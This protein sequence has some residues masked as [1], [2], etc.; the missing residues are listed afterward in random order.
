M[1]HAC[2]PR[3]GS[4]R[5]T[6][7]HAVSPGQVFSDDDEM[8]MMMDMRSSPEFG[9][10]SPVQ[11][12][13]EQFPI[14]ASQSRALLREDTLRYLT[15][16][17]INV[18]GYKSFFLFL[19]FVI[20]T[21][22]VVGMQ[23][24]NNSVFLLDQTLQ[25]FAKDVGAIE[26]LDEFWPWMETEFVPHV[27][28]HRWGDHLHSKDGQYITGHYLSGTNV[29]VGGITVTQQR[30]KKV[31]CA[32]DDFSI[33]PSYALSC[34]GGVYQ[35][36]GLT[37]AI[38]NR[39]TIE[40]PFDER[41]HL[42]ELFFPATSSL[43]DIQTQ[44]KLFGESA[45]LG[46]HTGELNIQFIVYNPDMNVMGR[47]K[48]TVRIASS[49]ALSTKYT[50]SSVPF[51]IYNGSFQESW[52]RRLECVWLL[53]FLYHFFSLIQGIRRSYDVPEFLKL[54]PNAFD[55]LPMFY[56][57]NERRRKVH[58]VVPLAM[59]VLSIGLPALWLSILQQYE[60]LHMFNLLTMEG[61]DVKAFVQPL[62]LEPTYNELDVLTEEQ[63]AI[64]RKHMQP[65]W[66]TIGN[67]DA[68][69]QMYFGFA[70]IVC[71]LFIFRSFE[72]FHFQKKLS[73]ITSTIRNVSTDLLHLFFVL[74][75]AIQLFAFIGMVVFGDELTHFSDYGD[76]SFSVWLMTLQIF[77]FEEHDSNFMSD[78][79]LTYFQM[80]YNIVVMTLLMKMVIAILIGGYESI[81]EHREHSNEHVSTVPEDMVELLTM[82]FE[83]LAHETHFV[84][85]IVD[86]YVPPL[87]LDKVLRDK[88]VR[89]QCPRYI[90]WSDL[91]QFLC[92]KCPE[93]EYNFVHV[94]WILRR[95][96][97][98]I[99]IDDPDRHG[100]QPLGE[101]AL[102]KLQET[103]DSFDVEKHG[104][105]SVDQL[106]SAM[107]AMGYPDLTRKQIRSKLGQ[108]DRQHA[109][110]I[111]LDEFCMIVSGCHLDGTVG[112][113]HEKSPNGSP[114]KIDASERVPSDLSLT[115]E[116]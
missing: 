105:M 55:E 15:K 102:G 24:D 71:S 115:S 58:V 56:D 108:I 73:A 57:H 40:L 39:T 46:P 107:T 33:I 9:P 96:G 81:L 52:Q 13:S 27:F 47:L 93:E 16:Y 7:Q 110:D 89:A 32:N 116:Q 78:N 29:L 3:D 88:E 109:G 38:E 23:R 45:I 85:H 99:P 63:V 26:A 67:L 25:L 54:P 77:K 22:G 51:D 114:L 64:F 97:S 100:A 53:L 2:T 72:H 50:I 4:P 28:K 84:R 86:G 101:A 14:M 34:W 19:L 90:E 42:D 37:L 106:R 1:P 44:L 80:A 41:T 104:H 92:D 87:H 59:Y 31:P 43:L 94:E 17:R 112:T 113:H 69:L 74:A 83:W 111:D 103:F 5:N 68:S 61:N 79:D 76:S 62:K 95:Y 30:R 12:C 21:L 49:G 6:L 35:T 75:L 66:D 18:S 91:L 8:D 36:E 48:H 98:E 20:C 70:G 65:L 82:L 60:E 11:V 10:R